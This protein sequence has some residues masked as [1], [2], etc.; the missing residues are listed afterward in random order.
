MLN[1]IVTAGRAGSSFLATQLNQH[2]SVACLNETHYLPLLLD[3]FGGEPT[4]TDDI[5]KIVAG[6]HFHDGRNILEANFPSLGISLEA[7][8]GW[9]Y[10][11]GK[12]FDLL[13]V[14]QFQAKLETFIRAKT[15]AKIVVDKTP[16]YGAHLEV[17]AKHLGGIRVVILSRDALPSIRS[18]LKHPGFLL[19]IRNGVNTWTDIMRHHDI[20]AEDMS[21]VL[22]P[23]EEEEMA[24]LWAWRTTQP[25]WQAKQ[26]D[27][28][29]MNLL[30][31]QMQSHPMEFFEEIESFFELEPSRDWVTQS[32][33]QVISPSTSAV[34]VEIP[35]SKHKF[36]W[37]RA[38]IGRFEGHQSADSRDPMS[39]L[40]TIPEV[41]KARSLMGYC[42]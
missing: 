30:Y 26:A 40:L 39:H 37:L 31:E 35:Y 10:E 41:S 1:L 8:N 27:L 16:C 9:K 2:P 24:K 34:N 22:R 15:G 6:T 4:K 33:K 13:T 19:K 42:P 18:M 5:M 7:W 17:F 36:R 25:I 21:L 11:L 14:A 29:Y 3:A 38:L 28:K 20:N 12:N 32:A 23:G